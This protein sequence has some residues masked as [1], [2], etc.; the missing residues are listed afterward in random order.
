MSTWKKLSSTYAHTNPYYKIRQDAV[1][2]PDGTEGT[3][4]VLEDNR[5]VFIV[6]ITDDQ[7][8]LLINLFRYTTQRDSWEIPAG[9]I[10]AG[11]EP[12]VAAKRELQ[13]E[14]GYTADTWEYLGELQM[15]NGKTDALGDIFVCKGLHTTQENHQAEEAIHTVTAFSLAEIKQMMT[16]HE[17]TDSNSISPIM[18]ALAAH[19]I[20]G[21]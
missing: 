19:K 1:I 6:A 3:F 21:L 5:A 20:G 11:E 15:S 4:Y 7:K 18:L 16:N 10:D 12:L 8:I 13:E 2:R 9:G 14:T 17:L